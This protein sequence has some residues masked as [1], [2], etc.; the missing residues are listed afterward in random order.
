M[1]NIKS[2]LLVFGVSVIFI[3]AGLPERSKIK[4]E[5]GYLGEEMRRR[6]KYL[7]SLLFSGV[8]GVCVC[9]YYIYKFF[10]GS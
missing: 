5:S 3:L 10:L 6:L 9:L 2:L 1:L 8:A 7:D 4:N